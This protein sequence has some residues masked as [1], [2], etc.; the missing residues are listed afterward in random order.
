MIYEI[1]RRH[2]VQKQTITEIAKYMR[3]SRPI[4]R[5]NLLSVEEPKCQRVQPSTPKPGP[6][7]SQLTQWLVE[8]AKLAKSRRRNGQRLF[9]GLQ[10][11]VYSGASDSVRRFARRWKSKNHGLKLSDAFVPLLFP[12]GDV[13]Q[14]DWSQEEVELG[15]VLQKIK[16]V[17]DLS[18][19][20]IC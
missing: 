3:L 1:L 4:V 16:P 20:Y 13:C 18:A 6:F 7:E 12:P 10:A 5:K 11:I 15:G 14:F 17:I 8:D 9:E 2:L 19:E